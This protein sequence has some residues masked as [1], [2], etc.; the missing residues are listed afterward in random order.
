MLVGTNPV[1][2]TILA[3]GP[4]KSDERTTECDGFQKPAVQF[5]CLVGKQSHLDL[6][7][8]VTQNADTATTYLRIGVGHSNNDTRD[9]PLHYHPG[10]WGCLPK[11]GTGLKSD[12]HCRF[13]EQRN[14]CF[15]YRRNGI[16]F[17][18]A[19]AA[20][21]VPPL[22]YYTSVGGYDYRSHHRIRRG[23]SRSVGGKFQCPPHIYFIAG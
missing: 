13:S 23:I 5:V 22:P 11:M 18:M 12:K 4:F 21:A 14:V 6:Y 19:L 9:A 20:A 17:G 16:N 7:A 3:A 8:R 2:I 1:H 15:G 10:T